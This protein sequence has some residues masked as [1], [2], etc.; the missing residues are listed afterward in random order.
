MLKNALKMV[1]ATRIPLVNVSKV[2]RV[3]NVPKSIFYMENFFQTVQ[4]SVRK[5]GLVI[6]VTQKF[7]QTTATIE[8][9]ATTVLVYV[10]MVGQAFLVRC[11]LVRTN[12]LSMDIVL[13]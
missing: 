7:V 4:Q 2:T 6:F 9:Y 10:Q 11:F 5:A 12:V 13:L 1:F 8:V 3:Q